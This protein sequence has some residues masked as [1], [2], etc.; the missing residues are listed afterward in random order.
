MLLLSCALPQNPASQGSSAQLA[1]DEQLEAG[2]HAQQARLELEA[3]EEVLTQD[4]LSESDL[5]ELRLRLEAAKTE[6]AHAG[7]ALERSEAKMSPEGLS[8]P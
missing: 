1:L 8:P 6:V 2:Q 5:V 3:L 7:E 4:G